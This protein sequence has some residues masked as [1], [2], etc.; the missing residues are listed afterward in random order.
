MAQKQ[1]VE[2]PRKV[3]AEQFTEGMSP[4]AV[5][6]HR[7]GLSPLVETGPPHVH[8]PQGEVWFLHDTDWILASKWAPTIPTGVMTD[9][10]FQDTFGA[11][12]P[13]EEIT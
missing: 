2:K 4:D 6:V 7:C 3:L 5:G 9:A 10:E 8:G 11:G 1:F 12:P 13:A